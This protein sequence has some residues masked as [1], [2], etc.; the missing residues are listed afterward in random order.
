MASA[1]LIE[2]E[3]GDLVDV[4]WYCCDDCARY[5]EAYAGWYGCVSP[6]QDERCPDPCGAYIPGE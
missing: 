4:R 5:D 6:S 1:V 3:T 2:D